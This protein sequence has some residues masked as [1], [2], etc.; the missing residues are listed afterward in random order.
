M[1]H[2]KPSSL[3]MFLNAYITGAIFLLQ[4]LRCFSSVQSLSC[5]RFF[6]TP[7]TAAHQAS[8]SITNSQSLLKL[9]SIESL[10]PSNH[11]LLCCPLLLPPSIFPS[12]MVFSSESTLR[13]R[14]PK[15][16]SFSFSISPSNEYSGLISFRMDWFDL[17]AVQRSLKS[18]P[19]SQFKSFSSSALSCLY[20][21]T[22]TSI[23]DT[24]KII[25][26]TRWTLLAK[27]LCFLTSCL[28]LT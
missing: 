4:L 21:P 14:W 27:C 18:S 25:A 5:V 23:H 17:Y 9:M 22:L 11:L 20:S 2:A 28:G 7:W 10:M 19:A 13:M 15:Y 24:G 1:S 6:V 16:W 26:L 12:I 8:L 3:R